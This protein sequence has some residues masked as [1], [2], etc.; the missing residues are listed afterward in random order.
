LSSQIKIQR[1]LA[2]RRDVV[3]GGVAALLAAVLVCSCGPK[4]KKGTTSTS[5]DSIVTDCELPDN[6]KFSIQ[7][8][9]TQTPIKVSFHA[10]DFAPV[11]ISDVQAGGGIW[12]KFFNAS[13]AFQIFDM[14]PAGGNSSTNAQVT[15]SCNNGTLAEGTV[16][17]K[18]FS[19]WS[20]STAA[21][22]VTTTCF[23]SSNNGS[24]ATIFNAIMEFN[25]VNFY[26]ETSG[27]FPDMQSIAVHELGHLLGLDHSCGP[28]GAPNTNQPNVACPD[29][30]ADPNNPMI[31]T[32]M[33]PQVF[34][35]PNTGQGEVKRTLTTNDQGRA[36]CAYTPG[37]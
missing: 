30:N 26:T 6:Q 4:G 16:L 5:S 23:R 25:Y 8:K 35:D 12:N 7:G 15:P 28:L 13:K 18:R 34:F 21:I 2:T 37:N 36:N 20:H 24:L 29:P 11:E 33:F 3:F 27:K 22:A 17:Y 19:N 31:A 9:W 10:G 1:A 32:V 14:G